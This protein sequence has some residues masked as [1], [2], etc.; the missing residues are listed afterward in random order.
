ML[1]INPKQIIPIQPKG[2]QKT[3]INIAA[4]YDILPLL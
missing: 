2:V 3:A 4:I 1:T